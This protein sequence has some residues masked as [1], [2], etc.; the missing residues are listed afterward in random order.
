MAKFPV[1]RATTRQM[2]SCYPLQPYTG[3]QVPGYYVGRLANGAA[4]TKD[5]FFAAQLDVTGGLSGMVMGDIGFWKSAGVKE[6]ILRRFPWGRRTAVF[7]PKDEYRLISDHL[8]MPSIDFTEITINPIDP[9]RLNPIQQSSMLAM[10]VQMARGELKPLL[11]V[12]SEVLS[13]ALREAATEGRVPILRTV[14]ECLMTPTQA[15]ADALKISLA[16]LQSDGRPLAAT[17]AK[18]IGNGELGGPFDGPTAPILVRPPQLSRFNFNTVEGNMRPLLISVVAGWL[19][20]AWQSDDR[21]WMFDQTVFEECWDYFRYLDFGR[22]ARKMLKLQRKRGS[23]QTFVVHRLTDMLAAGNAGS[24]Q[25]ALAQGLLADCAIWE[26]YRQR[27]QDRV[28]LQQMCGLNE[29][30]LDTVTTLLRKGQAL[31]KMGEASFVV[32][33]IA[34]KLEQRLVYTN[35]AVDAQAYGDD[36][37]LGRVGA[38]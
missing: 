28:P 7:D 22:M 5:E 6:G 33:Q 20:A 36:V 21:T 35:S 13:E 11:D 24:E 27:P 14:R 12:Q 15:S 17:I 16:E 9:D 34:T 29:I 26:L 23:S 18:F 38:F 32:Q 4:F 37:A 1:H 2:A 30:E 19:D 3:P 10:L 8:G 31:V 25:V